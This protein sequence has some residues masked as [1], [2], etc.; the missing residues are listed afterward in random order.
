MIDLEEI[1]KKLNSIF[2]NV[3]NDDQINLKIN[4]SNNELEKWD[5]LNHILLIL[6][7]E[8]KFSIKIAAGEIAE[9]NSISLICDMINE[10]ISG[11]V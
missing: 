6:E 1:I 7:I 8:K 9:L 2:R 3:L 5:S 10:K 11:E 4:T